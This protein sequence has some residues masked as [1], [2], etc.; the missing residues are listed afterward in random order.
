MINIIRKYFLFILLANITLAANR[1]SIYGLNLG[2]LL[3][4]GVLLLSLIALSRTKYNTLSLLLFFST[5][6]FKFISS[7]LGV[8]YLNQIG[9]FSSAILLILTGSILYGEK[10]IILYRQLIYFLA[11]SIPF[12]I[13]QKVGVHSFF[14]GWS[15][16]LFHDNDIY[17]FDVAKETGSMFKTLTMYPT[18]FTNYE[19]L[20][21]V[22]YQGRPTGLLYSNNVLSVIISLTLALH[23]SFPN[24]FKNKYSNLVLVSIAVLAMSTLVYGVL[25]I[26]II[27]FIFSGNIFQKRRALKV[28]YSLI[29]MM[30]SHYIFF[31]GLTENSFGAQNILSFGVRF[32]EIFKV[33]ELNYFLD[34]FDNNIILYRIRNL[35]IT[36]NSYSLIGSLLKKEYLYLVIILFIIFINVYLRSLK[37]FKERHNYPTIIYS[38][39]FLV[40]ILT[41]F[42]TSYLNAPSFQ[43]ILGVALF[44]ILESKTAPYA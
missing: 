25:I 8:I 4:W 13:I 43:V 6:I 12:M 36:E 32:G 7:F 17:S 23:F 16:E 3:Y 20:T 15:T 22:M 37:K 30:I 18:L 2:Q 9:D 42:A 33:L 21:Y 28:L 29:F 41:Q 39:L 24:S 1:W 31:P 26:L 19:K 38:T 40:G 27:I 35:H 14:Y 34:V 5:F 11:L 10:P 44:P